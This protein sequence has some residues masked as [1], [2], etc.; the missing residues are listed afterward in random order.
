MVNSK[1]REAATCGRCAAATLD[2]RLLTL[3]TTSNEE[4]NISS[5]YYL[6]SS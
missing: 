6:I 5:C 1:C 3:T 4:I 2:E